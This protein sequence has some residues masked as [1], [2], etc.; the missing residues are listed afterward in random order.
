MNRKHIIL[1]SLALFTL[2]RLFGQRVEFTYDDNGNR[3]TRTIIVEQLQSNT[4]TFPVINPKSLIT[5]ENEM[6]N[7]L[8]AGTTLQKDNAGAVEGLTRESLKPEEEKIV[9]IIYPNPS[10]GLIKI[11][12]TNLPLNSINEMRLYD[13]AGLEKLVKRNF[14]NH[15]EIDISHLRDGI[16]ILRIKINGSTFDWKVIKN[17]N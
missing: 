5:A 16:Y 3:L 7:E 9:T 4:V 15:V 13:L 1:T 6:A 8:E 10:I 12:I 14:D 2:M 11:D 17:H